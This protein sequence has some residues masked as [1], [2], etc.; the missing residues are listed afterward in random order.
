[1]RLW[2]K[3]LIPVLPDMQLRGQWRECCLIAKEL[4][5]GTL[6]HLLV[7]RV[8]EYPLEHFFRYC[9]RVFA[10][11]IDRGFRA[12]SSKLLQ[13]AE[14]SE[15]WG[16][17]NAFWNAGTIPICDLFRGWHNSRYLRQCLYN[18][19]E[20]HDCGGISDSEWARIVEKFPQI[21]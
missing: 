19:Q 3:D 5:D 13:Y 1:M 21:D 15:L 17:A 8:T 16:F 4:H 14:E 10:I 7:N 20:K 2:H 6:N 9:G 18:L 11:M 12:D